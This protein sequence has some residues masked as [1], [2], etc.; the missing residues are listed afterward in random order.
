MLARAGIFKVR[1]RLIVAAAI[2]LP[3][4]PTGEWLR[5]MRDDEPP[6]QADRA[7]RST[8]TGDTFSCRSASHARPPYRL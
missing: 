8:G 2:R 7:M 5:V 6:H 3:R 4:G 1:L